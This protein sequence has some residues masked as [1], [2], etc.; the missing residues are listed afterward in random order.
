MTYSLPFS[1][2]TSALFS[3]SMFLFSK[4]L[5]AFIASA[6]LLSTKLLMHFFGSAGMV[7]ES[8]GMPLRDM[9]SVTTE[10]YISQYIVP[11]CFPLLPG[12]SF[13]SSSQLLAQLMFL[14]PPLLSLN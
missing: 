6:T 8:H 3:E 4:S 1:F 13:C 12:G 5:Q 2:R 9:K 14:D 11:M 7:F 10:I